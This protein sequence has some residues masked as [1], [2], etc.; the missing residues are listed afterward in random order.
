MALISTKLYNPSLIPDIED[1]FFGQTVKMPKIHFMGKYGINAQQHTLDLIRY[2]I[3]SVFRWTPLEA[4]DYLTDAVLERFRITPYLK[5]IDFPL[6][7]TTKKIE[8]ILHLI[9][10]NIY[11][12]NKREFYLKIY[13]D[14]LAGRGKFP[15]N[16]FN[17]YISKERAE[18]C[19][20]HVINN[21]ILVN[22]IEELYRIFSSKDISLILKKY[23]LIL[24]CKNLYTNPVDFLHQALPNSQKDLFLYHYYTFIYKNQKALEPYLK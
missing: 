22:S 2:L 24:P 12:F 23:N 5:H 1:Y 3:E 14:V 21:Y 13:Q 19:L 9:Y 6:G 8:Y 15:K 10:P 11:K 20:Q 7:M 4:G 18:I 16:F 17:G